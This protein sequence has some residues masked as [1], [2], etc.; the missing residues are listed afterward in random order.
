M[1]EKNVHG[2]VTIRNGKVTLLKNVSELHASA[3]GAGDP[4]T[5]LKSLADAGW[6]VDGDYDLKI[7]REE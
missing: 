5:I 1:G 3:I 6:R 4:W 7:I 2:V